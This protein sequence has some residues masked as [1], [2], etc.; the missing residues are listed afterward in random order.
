MESILSTGILEY[1]LDADRLLRKKKAIK[2]EL[3]ERNVNWLNK[4]IAILG[5]STTNDIQDFLEIFLLREGIRPSFY[6]SEYNKY[7]EDSIFENPNLKTFAPD[8]IFIHTTSRNILEWPTASMNNE[9]TKDLLHKEFD[10]FKVMWEHLAE[11]Y[12]CPI[13]QNNFERPVYRLLGNKDVSDYR[14]RSNFVFRLNALLYDYASE[15]QNFFVHDIDYLAGQFGQECWQNRQYWNQFK[16]AL[17]L[18]AIPEF[19]RNLSNIIKSI[20][21][22]NK[23]VVTLDLDNTLWGGVVG[24]DGVENLVIGSETPVGESFSEFQCYLR[25]LKELGVLLTI[26]SKNDE[27]NARA[28]LQ[29]PSSLLHPDDFAHIQAN[30]LSKDINIR[31]T[32]QILSLGLDSFVF[33]DDNPAEREIVRTQI[34]A[35]SVLDGNKPDQFLSLLDHS[36]FFE[37]TELTKDDLVRNEMYKANAVRAMLQQSFSNY[38]EYL[39]SLEMKATIRDFEVAYLQRITQLTNKSNQ[40]NLTTKRYSDADMQQLV[41]NQNYIRLYGRLEDKF[42]DNGIVTV[43]A[44]RI[45]G[46]SLHIELWLMSCRVLKRDME[47]AMFDRLIEE[48][49]ARGIK[50][51]VGYYYPTAKNKMV[52][53]FYNDLGFTLREEDTS[54]DT[55]WVYQVQ[56]HVKKNKVIQI[57]IK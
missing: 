46:I 32:A 14:G 56:G 51:V 9:Q 39:L 27:D 40:F 24:D 15:H 43:L 50:E 16:Y 41:Q 1:P 8:V 6:A 52:K 48:C 55:V 47:L 49:D 34:P 42:G 28:G 37:V 10:R 57:I 23:K 17:S 12:S 2:R 3:L 38:T 13:I 54:G 30:W 44:G 35:V 21:G 20:Y 18:K 19:S 45:E 26:N 5:G 4:K 53:E 31:T 11:A 25:N 36:G 33:A 7:W 22:K 29:H